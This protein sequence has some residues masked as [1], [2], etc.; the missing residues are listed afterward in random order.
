MKGGKM[1]VNK[2]E[3]EKIESTDIQEA[4]EQAEAVV[5][6]IG[7]VL[8]AFA[9]EEYLKSLGFDEETY[10]HVANAMFRNEDWYAGDLGLVTTKQWLELFIENDPAYES[11]IRYTFENFGRAIVPYKYTKPWT[12]LLKQRKK[13]IYFLSNYSEEMFCQSKEQ[14]DFLGYFDGGL[15]SWEE[16]CMKP[17]DQIY[18]ILLKRYH[19]KP[20][21]CVFFDD[22]M[23]NV[24]GAR[25]AGMKAFLFHTDI[26]LQLL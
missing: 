20:E 8:V 25:R 15:L 10:E 11:Q 12:T 23:E 16:K 17:D 7:N 18:K 4:I 13:K 22:R 5:F 1:Q 26:P 9:W 3:E 21:K 6:D 2:L 24:E 19:L 14:L